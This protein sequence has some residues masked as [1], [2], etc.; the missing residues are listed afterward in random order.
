M[1]YDCDAVATFG[2]LFL[3]SGKLDPDI[4][5]KTHPKSSLAFSK[6]VALGYGSFLG[7]KVWKVRVH[8][9]PF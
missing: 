3:G 8:N 1:L 5:R 2:Y 7:R 4:I 9:G 6:A